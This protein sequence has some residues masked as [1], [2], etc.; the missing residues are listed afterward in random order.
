[1]IPLDTDIEAVFE[2]PVV[3]AVVVVAAAAAAA[4]GKHMLVVPEHEL[5]LVPAAEH[6]LELGLGVPAPAVVSLMFGRLGTVKSYS[7]DVDHGVSYAET[8]AVVGIDAPVVFAEVVVSADTADTVE[9]AVIAAFAELVGSGAF[10]GD[11]SV[12]QLAIVSV[13]DIGDLLANAAS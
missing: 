11:E 13:S 1:M 5:E 12:L 6:V 4:V 8:E 9:F 2:A 3:Q 7:E 10:A